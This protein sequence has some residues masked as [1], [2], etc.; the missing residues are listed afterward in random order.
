MVDN[1]NAASSLEEFCLQIPRL[2]IEQANLKLT[3]QSHRA[4]MASSVQQD[5]IA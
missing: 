2:E 3:V 5:K 4:F 1:S